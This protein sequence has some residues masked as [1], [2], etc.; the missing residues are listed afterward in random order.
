MDGQ[1]DVQMPIHAASSSIKS[2]TM[3]E[4]YINHIAAPGETLIID[5][6]ELNLHPDNQIVMAELIVRLVNLGVK[7]I[8]TTHSDYIVREINNR[9]KLFSADNSSKI[10]KKYVKNNIDVIDFAKVNVFSI[11]NNGKINT[12]LVTSHGLE[13]V[14]FDEVIIESS[15]KEELINSILGE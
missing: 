9:I 12:S 8:M 6:P 5:E 4:L 7:V 13:N 15:E 2:M 10:Y 1:S 14:I 11:N 3:L